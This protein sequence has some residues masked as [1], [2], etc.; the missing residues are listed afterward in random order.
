M[1]NKLGKPSKK[2]TFLA[3]MSAKA[4]SPPPRIALTTYEKNINFFFLHVQTYMFLERER[5]ETDY[6]AIK[7]LTVFFRYFNIS[8]NANFFSVRRHPD[9]NILKMSLHILAFQNIPNSEHFLFFPYNILFADKGFS[10]PPN[11]H[12]R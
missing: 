6:F 5:P 11:G 8:R 3:D 2:L 10:P 9:K 7:E 4:L 1:V 12:V